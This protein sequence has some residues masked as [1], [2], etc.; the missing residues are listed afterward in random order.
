[1]GQITLNGAYNNDNYTNSGAVMYNVPDGT[2]VKATKEDNDN[3][4][5]VRDGDAFI[6]NFYS[7]DRTVYVAVRQYEVRNQ[8]RFHV[9]CTCR[10]YIGGEYSH[11]GAYLVDEIQCIL[12]LSLAFEINF[13][14]RTVSQGGKLRKSR[15]CDGTSI[16]RRLVMGIPPFAE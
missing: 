12:R 14:T 5:G 15:E 1:M 10:L 16:R 2:V 3:G 7:D 6:T 13:K 4:F 8:D 11:H 9:R